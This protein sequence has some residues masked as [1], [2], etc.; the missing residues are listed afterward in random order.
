[1]LFKTKKENPYKKEQTEKN[2]EDIFGVNKWTWFLPTMPVMRSD[3]HMFENVQMSEKNSKT[4][5]SALNTGNN[6]EI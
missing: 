1:M 5:Y 3:G 4:E 2:L 6:N